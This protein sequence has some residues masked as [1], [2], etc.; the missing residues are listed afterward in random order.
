MEQCKKITHF[1][2]GSSCSLSTIC[3]VHI[4]L[5]SLFC[6]NIFVNVDKSIIRNSYA[7]HSDHMPYVD[8]ITGD[9]NEYLTQSWHL[10]RTEK[11]TIQVVLFF[12]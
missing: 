10:I 5:S 3:L 7:C 1:V 12:G 8:P 4:K 11:L 2:K 9:E 6:F